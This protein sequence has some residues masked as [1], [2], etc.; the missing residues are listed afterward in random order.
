MKTATKRQIELINELQNRGAIIECT[1]SGNP[2][3]SMFTSFEKA[4][5]YI[6]K[7][8]YLM[9]QS[10]TNLSQSEYGGIYNA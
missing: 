6:K 1:Y 10:R 9:R 3:N 7:W 2:D 8:G 4:D 5:V